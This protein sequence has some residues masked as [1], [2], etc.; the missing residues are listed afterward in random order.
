MFR[1]DAQHSFAPPN[2]GPDWYAKILARNKFAASIYM[3]H[4]GSLAEALRLAAEFP[5]IRRVVPCL[6]PDQLGQLQPHPLI[7][8]VHLSRPAP[9]ALAELQRRHLSAEVDAVHWPFECDIRVALAGMPEATGL[10]ANVYVK[11]TGFRLP[12]TPE[13]AR[14]LRQLLR[15]PGPDRIMFASGWPYGGGTWKETLAAFTQSLG[16][17][18]IEVREQIL[19]GTARE[20]YGL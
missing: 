18:P 17:M 9:E 1:V 3:P 12:A 19:G 6:D 8:S 16:A 5:Y 20:F 4:D 7:S 11:M 15:D 13:Q 2:Q 10:P 14:L